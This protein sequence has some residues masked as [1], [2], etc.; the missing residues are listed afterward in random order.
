ML[1]AKK[2]AMAKTFQKEQK[3]FKENCRSSKL[4]RR[5]WVQV[6]CRTSKKILETKNASICF[7]VKNKIGAVKTKNTFLSSVGNA[8]DEE[9]HFW[10]FLWGQG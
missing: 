8:G 7:K 1:K 9:K 3:H 2:K 5:R 6:G 10:H 4:Q